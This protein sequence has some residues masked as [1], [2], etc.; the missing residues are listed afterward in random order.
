MLD[1]H[2]RLELANRA[3]RQFPRLADDAEQVPE[4][5]RRPLLESISSGLPYRVDLFLQFG[6]TF[7]APRVE[8][9]K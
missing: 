2:G 3:A 4:G 7:C 8:A 1:Y 6:T 9:P 5:V